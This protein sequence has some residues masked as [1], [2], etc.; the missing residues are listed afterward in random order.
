MNVIA[1]D[2]CTNARRVRKRWL[3]KIQSLLPDGL[4]ASTTSSSHSRRA[5]RGGGG[6]SG[7]QGGEAALQASSSPFELDL[8]QL[9][10]SYLGLEAPM[11]HERRDREVAGERER[12]KE[13]SPAGLLP[14]LQFAGSHGG[15]GGGAQAEEGL[16]GVEA[17]GGGRLQTEQPSDLPLSLSSSSSSSSSHASPQPAEP[18]P[19]HRGLAETEEK[20]AE[21]LEDSQ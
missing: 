21:P 1:A 17:D 4:P 13:A 9:G 12:E 15:G 14:H 16:M 11:Y 3:P 2:M 19:P 18:A 7:G 20:G 8:R 6:A 5:K 10:A